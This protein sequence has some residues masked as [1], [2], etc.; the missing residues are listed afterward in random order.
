MPRPLYPE[1]LCPSTHWLG[2]WVGPRCGVDNAERIK[3][4]PYRDSKSDPSAVQPE[5]GICFKVLTRTTKDPT[6]SHCPETN[7]ILSLPVRTLVTEIAMPII[8][9]TPTSHYHT[10]YVYGPKTVPSISNLTSSLPKIRLNAIRQHSFRP[11]EWPLKQS[12]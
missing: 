9:R 8:L 5:T 1:V 3:P 10:P 12:L 4:C 2:G 11:S 7:N 6:Y